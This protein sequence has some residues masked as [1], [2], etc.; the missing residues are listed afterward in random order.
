MVYIKFIRFG[1]SQ[2][3]FDCRYL[4]QIMI[5]FVTAEWFVYKS[6]DDG[7]TLLS[8]INIPNSIFYYFTFNSLYAN[9]SYMMR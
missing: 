3:H 8:L 4:V 9:L 1:D 2:I 6:Y 5:C 7:I